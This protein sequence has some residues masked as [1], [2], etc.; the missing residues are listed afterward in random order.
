MKISSVNFKP[1]KKTITQN[2]K[3]PAARIINHV[4][5]KNE[6][7]FA[8]II[9]SVNNIDYAEPE[10]QS[11]LFTRLTQNIYKWLEKNVD[12]IRKTS[13]VAAYDGNRVTLKNGS[14]TNKCSQVIH[15]ENYDESVGI[16][17]VRRDR[18]SY[19]NKTYNPKDGFRP[20]Y[21]FAKMNGYT[22]EYDGLQ[23]SVNNIKDIKQ[24]LRTCRLYYN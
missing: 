5:P 16:H 24:I 17:L 22:F 10:R 13:P 21:M 3:T 7:P 14:Y 18:F 8:W 1:Y 19:S 4:Y 11:K 23:M 12:E 9:R 2:L 15:G 20:P 6:N